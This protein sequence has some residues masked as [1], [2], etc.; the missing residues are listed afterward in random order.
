MSD[1]NLSRKARLF[2]QARIKSKD[3]F[4]NNNICFELKTQK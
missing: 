1:A 2:G 3:K 4:V